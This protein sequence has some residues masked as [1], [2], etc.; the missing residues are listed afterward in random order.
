MGPASSVPPWRLLTLARSS[1][2]EWASERPSGSDLEARQTLRTHNPPPAQ[3]DRGPR[4]KNLA[5]RARHER[6]GPAIGGFPVNV[7]GIVAGQ[8]VTDGVEFSAFSELAPRPQSGVRKNNDTVGR[9]Q[10]ASDEHSAGTRDTRQPEA[11]RRR[12]SRCTSPRA[13]SLLVV[14]V[15]HSIDPG[16][17]EGP[18]A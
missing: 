14:P 10:S 18:R 5:V 1:A 17:V 11:E 2:R 12:H 8:I 9:S 6:Q 15:Q 3:P 4:L 7:F 16:F 13:S